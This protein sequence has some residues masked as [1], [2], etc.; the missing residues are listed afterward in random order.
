MCYT[1]HALDQFLGDLLNYDIPA[2]SMVR[3]G[4]RASQSTEHLSL[5]NQP[6]GRFWYNWDKINELR[7]DASGHENK[8]RTHFRE[9]LNDQDTNLMKYLKLE[10]LEL[11]QAFQVP[12]ETE[13]GMTLVGENGHG[14]DE[15]YLISRWTRGLDAGVLSG[16][17]HVQASARIW[18]MD[19]S[20]RQ[21]LLAT[22]QHERVTKA[23]ES[24]C[25]AGIAYNESDD[26]IRQEFGESTVAVLR[27]KRIIACTTTGAA[28]YAE[29]IKA[30]SPEFLLVE[31]AGE[32][33]ESHILT[34]LSREVDQMILIGDHKSVWDII[35]PFVTNDAS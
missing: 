21:Q 7:R 29:A 28:I 4:G 24:I 16:E 6:R 10:H 27:R 12:P 1:N 17:P 32:I 22:W 2:E 30:I 18:G 13:D 23:T 33:L 8:L 20:A 25:Q 31:E 35:R 19:H 5:R 34:A 15:T 26:G 3:L 11:F 14:I 9:L